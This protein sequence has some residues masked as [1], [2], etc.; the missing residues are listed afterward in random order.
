MKRLA[1]MVLVSLL[2]VAAAALPGLAQGY[3]APEQ[4]NPKDVYCSGF[5]SSRIGSDLRVIG[6]V[7]AI[8][9]VM[10]SDNDYV[11][12]SKG[13]DGG[14]G[15]GQ[16]YM[17]VRPV[18]NNSSPEVDAFTKEHH[19]TKE[20]K[21]PWY[22]KEYIGQYYQDVG[23]LEVKYVY[24]TTSTALVT[25]ACDGVGEG[26]YLVPMQERPAPEYKPSSTFDRFA[27]PSGLASGVIL[28]GKDFAYAMGQGDVLYAALGSSQG[29][30]VGDYLRA[31]RA[32]T[33]T[34]FKGSYGMRLGHW[35]RYRGIP[36]GADIPPLRQDLPREVLGE[37]LVVHVGE[38]ASTAIITE[39]LI[40]IHAGDFV[41]LEPPAAPL[42]ALTV[43]PA[44]IMRGATATL[45][46]GTRL[47]QTREITPGV[48]PV[49][50]RTGSVNV[51]PTQ[52]TTYT[53]MVRGAGGEAQ[54]TATLTVVQPP[55]PA[56]APA[57]APA[58]PSLQ[59]MFN[60]NVQDIFFDFDKAD[61]TAEALAI[62][63]R[64]AAFLQAN[65]TAR[66]LIEGHCDEFGTAE[67]NMALGVRRAQM[68][69]DHLVSMGANAAQLDTASLGK[70][71]PFCTESR[72]EECRRM[73]RRAHFVLRQ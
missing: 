51:S 44:T 15:V 35:E 21:S 37:A 72:R 25:H 2:L 3:R 26:D 71:R 33:G 13:S 65:P 28:P 41:E 29:V 4:A 43:V 67:Y 1:T 20:F 14:V 12:L 34:N 45:S 46:W 70:T 66:V 57:P 36:E 9:R 8:G 58:G 32:G 40:E 64:A 24:G 54:A 55:P 69:K 7:D 16:R 59:D 48:G 39:S 18:D 73:N 6:G 52:T 68:T 23:Q 38:N 31:Y 61:I 53:L 22:E 63:K 60:Q 47:A 49:T 30:K 19:M 56:P 62:L 11:Y 17:I 42:A 27:P 10:Y 5:L 50:S